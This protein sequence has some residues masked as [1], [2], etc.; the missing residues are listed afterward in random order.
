M[1]NRAGAVRWAV[2]F[3]VAVG[4][5][6][7]GG[8]GGDAPAIS[9]KAL[10]APVLRAEGYTPPQVLQADAAV[11]LRAASAPVARWPARMQLEALALPKEAALP[12]GGLRLV[13]WPRALAGAATPADLAGQ[14]RWQVNPGGVQVAALSVTA[15]GSH[16]LRL[17]LRIEALPQGALLRIYSQAQPGKVYEVAAQQVLQTIERNLA[18]G[19][20]GDAP[21][22][23]WT[24][25]L[26]A[27]EQTLEI[28]LPPGTDRSALRVAVPQ[29]SHI[30]DDLSLPPEGALASKVNESDTCNVDATCYDELAAQR[31]AVA[32]MLFTKNGSTY[33]CTGTLLND[34]A[35]SGTP[36]FLSANHC[37]STQTVAS[38]LQTDW[39]YRSSACNSRTLSSASVRRFAG[40]TLLY[41]S[42]AN[43]TAFMRLNEA[44]PA[45]AA[46]AAW[47][48]TPQVSGAA[49]FGLHH[50]RTDL[51]KL[52]L[53]NVAG[54]L[55][56]SDASGTQFT[57][58]GTSG[59]YYQVKWSSGTTEA[60]S[61]G[62]ALFR[63]AYVVGTLY[64]GAAS[65]TATGGVDAYGRLD[66]AYND[67]LKKWLADNSGGNGS[68]TD[69]GTSALGNLFRVMMNPK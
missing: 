1:Q 49:V 44:P 24:P 28:E 19:E 66:I 36:Y 50:P 37:I 6:G 30:F 5:L 32:R 8:G 52:S 54:Q 48:A 34:A 38:S 63:G 9:A 40:A 62:S 21:R 67:G 26:G 22:T 45:G 13:G 35:S 57:C 10:A 39:F 27:D 20:T 47:D 64:G 68:G 25:E 3:L 11:K 7:C 59:N 53:G 56:C 43:D 29:V 33:A 51:L 46:F 61:S 41:A 15:P 2:G 23:W 4:L 55:A 12:E 65:C 17:G 31:N 42:S 58:S 14:L 16:G 60:G 69:G 18:S